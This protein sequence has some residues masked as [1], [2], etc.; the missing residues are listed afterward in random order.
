MYDVRID[1]TIEHINI[2]RT[3]PSRIGI[4]QRP[5]A[6]S[7]GTSR[8]SW[9]ATVKNTHN[10]IILTQLHPTSMSEPPISQHAISCAI[11]PSAIER[12]FAGPNLAACRA[13]EI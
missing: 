11:V 3:S 6:L 8:K 7:P 4:V 1:P 9:I 10:A 2:P 13:Y 12:S 5:Q